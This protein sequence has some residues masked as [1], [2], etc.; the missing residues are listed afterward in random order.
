MCPGRNN[1][2]GRLSTAATN[3]ESGNELDVIAAVVI[4]V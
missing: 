4:D 3:I 1:S 2:T